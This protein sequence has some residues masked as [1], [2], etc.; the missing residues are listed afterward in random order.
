[1]AVMTLKQSTATGYAR[2]GSLIIMHHNNG[3]RS[4]IATKQEATQTENI[5]PGNIMSSLCQPSFMRIPIPVMLT[6]TI[7]P[8]KK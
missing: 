1:M 6:I 8:K 5:K 3:R 7:A 4:S 2:I